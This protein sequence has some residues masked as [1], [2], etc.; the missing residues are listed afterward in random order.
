MKGDYTN[1]HLTMDLD[2]R[3]LLGLT[4]LD[5]TGLGSLALPGVTTLP[6]LKTVPGLANLPGA[7]G[8]GLPQPGES[9]APPATGPADLPVLPGLPTSGL[10]STLVPVSAAG[11]DGAGALGRQI[12]PNLMSLL[13]GGLAGTTAGAQP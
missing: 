12:D 7:G 11:T 2:L 8:L 6:D 10:P 1:L 4:G 5:G 3:S 9:S 13:L